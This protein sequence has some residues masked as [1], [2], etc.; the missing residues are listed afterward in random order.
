MSQEIKTQVRAA[1]VQW[2]NE[3]IYQ[4]QIAIEDVEDA[5][6]YALV[7]IKDQIIM[8]LS[9]QILQ[10]EMEHEAANKDDSLTAEENSFPIGEGELDG[11]DTDNDSSNGLSSG[12]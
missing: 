9:G 3:M 7:Q 5:L 4:N 8:N 10:H 2:A 6:Y 11:E 1:A 12:D